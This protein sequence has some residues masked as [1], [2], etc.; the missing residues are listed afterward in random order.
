MLTREQVANGLANHYSVKF[1]GD[2]WSYFDNAK[3]VYV[4]RGEGLPAKYTFTGELAING[5][6]WSLLDY[7]KP[8][9]ARRLITQ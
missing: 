3:R 5:E 4:V 7:V 2:V 1:Q 6:T 8:T 9:E